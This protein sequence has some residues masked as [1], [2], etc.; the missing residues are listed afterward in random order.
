V[1][2]IYEQAGFIHTGHTEIVYMAQVSELPRPAEGRIP[3]LTLRRS[4]GINGTRLSAELGGEVVG[5][6]EVESREDAGRPGRH[7]GWADIGNLHVRESHRR[8]GVG[9]WLVGQAA[10]WLHLARIERVLD[11]AWLEHEDCRGFLTAVGFRELTRIKRRWS[12]TAHDPGRPQEPP[13]L[14]RGAAEKSPATD[15]APLAQSV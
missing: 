4:V 12:R 3:Q 2:S 13:R 6:V 14:A 11:Y 15:V 5:Y 7:G 10:D 1:Q 9:A 8:R